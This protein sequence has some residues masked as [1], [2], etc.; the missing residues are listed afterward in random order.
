[1]RAGSWDQAK[2]TFEQALSRDKSRAAAQYQLAIVTHRGLNDRVK[3]L[4]ILQELVSDSD[5]RFK[6]ASA[7]KRAAN[8][9]L[10]RWRASDRSGPIPED[11]TQPPTGDA[12]PD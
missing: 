3:A 4:N 6:N 8:I 9:T 10:R 2:K 12:S 7:V 5:G 1:M 11:I